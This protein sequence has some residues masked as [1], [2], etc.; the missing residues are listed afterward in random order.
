MY[1]FIEIKCL[2]ITKND[3]IYKIPAPNDNLYK[4]VRALAHEEVLFT[5]LYYE[6]VNALPLIYIVPKYTFTFPNDC[7]KNGCS[8]FAILIIYNNI[9][10]LSKISILSLLH[11]FKVYDTSACPYLVSLYV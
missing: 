10:G 2:Y 9:I 1:L 11:K 6:T 5:L 4:S 8:K 3:D 7:G